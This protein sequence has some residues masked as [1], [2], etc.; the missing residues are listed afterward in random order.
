MRAPTL[1]A[2]LRT[3][4]S[5]RPIAPAGGVTS[6]LWATASSNSD[7]LGLVDAVSERGVDDDRH[8]DVGELRREGKDCVVELGEAG[9]GATFGRD[10]GTVDDDQAGAVDLRVGHVVIS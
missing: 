2:M 8:G 5:P 10:V 6:S 9:D 3:N 4:A 1:L 7:D